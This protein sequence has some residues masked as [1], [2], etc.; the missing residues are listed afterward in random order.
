MTT[1][2]ILAALLAL[3]IL[4]SAQKQSQAGPMPNAVQISGGYSTHGTGD[5]LGFAVDFSYEHS[6]SN[7]FDLTNG[8]TTTVHNDNSSPLPGLTVGVQ[9]TSIFNTN[10]NLVSKSP[11]KIRI[12]AGAVLRYEST[13][14]PVSYSTFTD[15]NISP[16]PIVIISN[17]NKLNTVAIGYNFGL[18]FLSQVSHKHQLGIRMSFQSDTNGSA[19]TQVNL[20]FGRFVRL[21]EN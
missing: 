4:T 10:L 15:P 5:L 1:K 12:G 14:L 9:L 8:I 6:L 17:P 13:S 19:I 7:R 3:P 2:T 20:I 21:V 16:D 11:K 18:S